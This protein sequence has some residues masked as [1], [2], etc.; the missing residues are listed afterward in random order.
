MRRL[1][2]RYKGVDGRVAV[3]ERAKAQMGGKVGNGGVEQ[4]GEDARAKQS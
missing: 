3:L 2:M 4:L 1:P